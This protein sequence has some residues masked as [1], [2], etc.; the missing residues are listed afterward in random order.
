M[1]ESFSKDDRW[2]VRPLFVVVAALLCA[3]AIIYD[4]FRTH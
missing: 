4:V 3:G 2:T 1:D